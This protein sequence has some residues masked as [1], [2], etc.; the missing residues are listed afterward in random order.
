M[1]GLLHEKLWW[2]ETSVGVGDPL[3]V[4]ILYLVEA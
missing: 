3:P 2:S 1:G 4:V